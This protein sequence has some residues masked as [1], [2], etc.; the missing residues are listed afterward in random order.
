MPLRCAARCAFVSACWSVTE[1]E[2]KRLFRKFKK[3]D[4][5]KSGQCEKQATNGRDGRAQGRRRA[6]DQAMDDRARRPRE[7][8]IADVRQSGRSARCCIVQSD[9]CP[10]T[11]SVQEFLAIPE[12]EH[13]PL[14]NRVVHTFDIDK[15]GEVD[16]REFVSS[17]S[18]FATHESQGKEQKY[19]C[20][21]RFTLR[22]DEET[23]GQLWGLQ[24]AGSRDIGLAAH[25]V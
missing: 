17:L 3:L 4:V 1:A 22:A 18:V 24:R 11:L 8:C 16:F 19:K 7:C 13:N 9:C 6:G 12:L 15:S 10:G 25:R 23:R 2:I 21:T 20:T 5:D 14:V